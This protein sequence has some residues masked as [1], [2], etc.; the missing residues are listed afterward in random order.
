MESHIGAHFKARCVVQAWG[1]T[2]TTIKSDVVQGYSGAFYT[3]VILPFIVKRMQQMHLYEIQNI[4]P[5]P[6]H[7]PYHQHVYGEGGD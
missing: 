3:F 2:A 7:S 1:T 6:W 4:E 5:N